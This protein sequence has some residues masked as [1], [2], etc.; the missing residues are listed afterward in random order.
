MHILL[1]EDDPDTAEFI[2]AGL[3][4][5][6]AQV[7]HCDNAERAML[8]ASAHA[9]DVI[10]FDRLLPN[11]DGLDAVRILRASKVTTPIIMLTALSDTADRVAGLEA[12]ADDYLVKPFAFAELYARLKALARRQ[13]LRA[14]T[15]ELVIGELRLNRTSRQVL[16][17]G[18]EIELMPKEYQ[19]LEYMMQHP[20]QLITKTM[21]LE[22]VW[23]FSFDPKTSLVQTH[24]SRLRNKLDK[25]FTFDM[26]KTIRGS[27][28][29]L[30][31][32]TDG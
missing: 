31:G 21:L 28:Y 9:F 22:Q 27:G 26:I 32:S 17:A 13:P 30:T 29:L 20:E 25:P 4:Q 14:D 24:V 19:I 15:L 10:I 1:V 3:A 18:R 2:C 5:H 12:G 7:Q 16:R 23:G 6:N 11:M 8:S